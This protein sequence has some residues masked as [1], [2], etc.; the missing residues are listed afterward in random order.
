MKTPEQ[1]TARTMRFYDRYGLELEQI[2]NLLTIKLKQLALAYTINNRL[3]PE[4]VTVN[5]RVKTIRSFLKKLENDSWPEF[6][7]PTE[8]IKDLIGAR[9]VCWF[10][11]DCYGM[12]EA[13]NGSSHFKVIDDGS[14]PIKDYN[15]NPQIAGYRAIHLFAKVDY[16]SVQKK[17]DQVTVVPEDMICEIQ[18]RT[19]FQDAWAD[20][21]HEFFWK[22]KVQGVQSDDHEEFLAAFAERLAVEDKTLLRMRGAYQRLADKKQAEG[23]R[24]GFKDED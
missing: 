15:K 14:L 5:G 3:P 12:L 17:D 10:I 24:E 9:I 23:R 16:E 19:K 20:T 22:A 1:L 21:T 8:V 2:K 18:I 6:Y 13:I 11:D 4:A 7:Y